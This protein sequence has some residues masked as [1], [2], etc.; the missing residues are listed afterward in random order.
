[1]ARVIVADMDTPQIMAL[2]DAMKPKM[3]KY[4]AQDPTENPKQHAFLLLNCKEAFFGGGCG[5][6]KSSALLMA[7]LQYVDVPGYNAILFRKTFQELSLPEALLDRAKEWLHPYRN[8]GEIHWNEKNHTY[9]F[10]S[11]ATLSFGYLEH[12]NDRFRYQSAE[13][14]FIGF[15]ELTEFEE[16]NYRYLFSRLRRLKGSTV[17]LRMRSA[18]TPGGIG[19]EWVKSRFLIAGK[20]IFIPALMEDNKFLDLISYEESLKELDAVTREQLR[21][22]NWEVK[23]GGSIFDR[24]WFKI[25]TPDELPTGYVASV[26]YWD[27]ASSDPKKSKSKDPAWTA[28]VRMI[29]K[30]GFYYVTNV[31]RIRKTPYMV[32][33]LIKN[34]AML[35]GYSTDIWMEQEPGSAGVNN[36]DHYAREVLKGYTFR[37]RKETGSKVI[38]ATRVSVAAEQG[39]IFLVQGA[40]NT[41]FLD[42]LEVFPG[43]RYKD[44]ADAFSGVY[45]K[46]KNY[47]NYSHIPIAVGNDTSYWATA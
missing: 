38:R 29:E 41:P 11:G 37:G 26:R 9:T 14:Q 15:D 42:E 36:I 17:P 31:V 30:D 6:G 3:T 27:L 10:P 22:G 45:D 21:Y 47:I 23:S 28:G 34:T 18:G 40:W 44:Q 25:I 4:I 19:H 1:M 7:A 24:N 35:D 12:L 13:F 16:V 33:N 8:S 43:G 20:G 2:K 5:G 46:L 39:R 32:E